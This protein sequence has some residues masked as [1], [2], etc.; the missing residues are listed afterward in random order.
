[1][2]NTVSLC[3]SVCV[4]P[5][6]CA[7][8]NL[9]C[10]NVPFMFMKQTPSDVEE[11][12]QWSVNNTEALCNDLLWH[13]N[14]QNFCKWYRSGDG[15]LPAQTQRRPF[16]THSAASLSI[17]FVIAEPLFL[18]YVCVSL[19]LL[20]FFFFCWLSF[21]NLSNSGFCQGSIQGCVNGIWF[22]HIACRLE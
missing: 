22:Q 12:K 5:S 15:H 21:L 20:F 1:M 7:W 9:Y 4:F 14:K 11:N 8:H 2:H 18:S 16:L 3:L 17:S 6:S 13:S 19:F 10:T